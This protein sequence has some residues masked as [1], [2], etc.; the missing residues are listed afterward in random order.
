MSQYRKGHIAV[1]KI[2]RL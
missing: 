1:D 2:Y